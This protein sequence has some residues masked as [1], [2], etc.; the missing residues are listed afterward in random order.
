MGVFVRQAFRVATTASVVMAVW[1]G[2]AVGARAEERVISMYHIHTKERITITYWKDGHFIP[3]ALKK[4]NW[5]L[6]DWR[7][8]KAIRMDPRTIDLIWKL[9]EDLGSKEPVWIIC[10]H[11]T[12]ATNAM[13]RRIGRHVARR[14]RHITG[15]A[16]DFRFPDVPNWKV[17]N[18][19]LAYGVGGVGYYGEGRNSFIHAD[20]GRVRHWPRLSAR[21]LAMIKQRWR[22]YIGYRNRRPGSFMIAATRM[23]GGGYRVA[24]RQGGRR[25]ILKL[26]GAERS[27]TKAFAAKGPIALVPLPKSRNFTKGGR[28][29]ASA[30]PLPQPRPYEVL[31][32]AATTMEILPASAPA[33]ETNFAP[34]NPARDQLGMMIARVAPEALENGNRPLVMEPTPKED[35]EARRR[36]DGTFYPRVNRAGKGDLAMD[37]LEGRAR[38]VPVIG[39]RTLSDPHVLN[40]ALVS[41]DMER[42]KRYY[43][44]PRPME[45][46]Q[47]QANRAQKGDLAAAVPDV[48]RALAEQRVNRI[49]KGD[50][51]VER[52]RKVYGKRRLT[53][54]M[55]AADRADLLGTQ[56]PLS[57]R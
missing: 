27:S 30:V 54:G 7:K 49:G 37:I 18:L 23:K 20:T 12:A 41:G 38:N 48:G 28:Q 32:Q 24:S 10:G 11:R 17:R 1:G 25:R 16:I 15:Q 21:K 3:S 9:H 47:Q 45:R 4:L 35:L 13:L 51:M 33:S 55:L 43:G 19:A 31:V 8:N 44:T 57:F 39:L 40:A 26:A 46:P 42:I 22:S 29:V 36:P 50:L 34:R 56:K 6:R 5:F 2:V 14:S 52:L 53:L